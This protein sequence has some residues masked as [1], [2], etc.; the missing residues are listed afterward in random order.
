MPILPPPP[1][2]TPRF[3]PTGAVHTIVIVDMPPTNDVLK[4]LEEDALP[5]TDDVTGNGHLDNSTDGQQNGAALTPP[6]INGRSLP[7]LFIRASD[8]VGYHSGRTIAC[9]NVFQ[10]MDMTMPPSQTSTTTSPLDNTWLTAAQVAAQ[11]GAIHGWTLRV[12]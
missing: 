7:L 1:S 10:Q 4:A 6:S 8:G 11:D 3:V 9:E 2:I 12:M 5:V